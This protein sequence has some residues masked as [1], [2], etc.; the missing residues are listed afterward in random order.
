MLGV[1]AGDQIHLMCFPQDRRVH[2][3]PDGEKEVL[4]GPLGLNVLY[5]SGFAFAT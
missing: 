4:N 5:V 3:Q 1:H 2:V